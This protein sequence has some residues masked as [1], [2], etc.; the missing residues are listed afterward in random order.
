VQRAPVVEPV[1]ALGIEPRTAPVWPDVAGLAL[2]SASQ[3]YPRLLNGE[4][5][6]RFAEQVAEEAVA[7]LPAC[8]APRVLDLA[9]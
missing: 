4:S 8:P 2:A 5:V 3:I 7:R 6:V 9:A 1:H